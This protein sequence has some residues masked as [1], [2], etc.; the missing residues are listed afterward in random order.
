M[1][2][3]L[4]KTSFQSQNDI[5][6]ITLFN[7]THNITSLNDVY[8]TKREVDILTCLI[9]GK[10]NK[11]IASLLAISHRTVGTHLRN[12]MG[13]FNCHSREGL[14]QHIEKSTQFPFFKKYYVHLLIQTSFEKCLQNI[15]RI[16][17]GKIFSCLIVYSSKM[18]ERQ[19]LN[20]L[21]QWYF[22]W[23]LMKTSHSLS[24]QGTNVEKV[25]PF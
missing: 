2:I 10:S 25:S 3:E 20:H 14:I 12:L 24:N 15:A 23:Y 7:K 1:H 11:S 19:R 8:L 9:H 17:H 13:K 16:I 21:A 22:R 5:N 6:L 4:K 18:I